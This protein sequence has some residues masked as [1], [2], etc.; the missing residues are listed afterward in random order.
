MNLSPKHLIKIL[1]QNG[2]LFKR[3]KGSHQ[4]Y[5]NSITNKTVIVPIHGGKD[6][7]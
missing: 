7:K 1:E 3:A 2:F 5:H 4:L 6:M